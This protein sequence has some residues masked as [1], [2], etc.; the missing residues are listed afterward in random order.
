MKINVDQNLC[1]GCGACEAMCSKCFKLED[2]VAVVVSQD[3]ADCNV[4]DI[5]TNC[6]AGA[7]TVEDAA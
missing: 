1:I 5:A 6:P 4:N 3:C 2:G 7:I